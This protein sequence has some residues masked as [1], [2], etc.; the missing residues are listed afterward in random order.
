MDFPRANCAPRNQQ[1]GMMRLNASEPAGDKAVHVPRCSA[2][3]L[4]Y[5]CLGQMETHSLV[6]TAMPGEAQSASLAAFAMLW[7]THGQA[8]GW[9]F[10]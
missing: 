4:L 8:Y 10:A 7:L 6:L 9:I 3:M 5:R 1:C 2:G